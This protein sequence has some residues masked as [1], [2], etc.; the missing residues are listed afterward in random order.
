[1][2]VNIKASL[3]A[4]NHRLINRSFLPMILVLAYCPSSS[5]SAQTVNVT[6]SVQTSNYLEG[7]NL[8]DN[9]LGVSLAADWSFDQGVFSGLNCYTSTAETSV[10]LASGC[11]LYAGYFKAFGKADQ[12]FSVAAT[13]HLY[14]SARGQE[15]DFTELEANWHLNKTASV[16][17]YYTDDWLRRGYQSYALRGDIS[18]EISPRFRANLSLI[19][20]FF[21]SAAPIDNLNYAKAS[22]EYS[23][24]RWSFEGSI[25]SA[26]N[27]LQNILP[28]DIDDPEIGFSI[29]YQLY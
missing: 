28:F 5:S 17:A 29:S 19:A 4:A 3:N 20:R 16:S 2:M 6:A 18:R 15:W 7:T 1:M 13:R 10:N 27:D 21:E 12:A 11:D 9:N 14:V 22:I 8:T 25:I 23:H 24:R 26:D